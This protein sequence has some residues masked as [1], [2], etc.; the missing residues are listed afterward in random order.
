V[1]ALPGSIFSPTS[2][3]PNSLIKAGAKLVQTAQDIL[4]EL[5]VECTE[6]SRKEFSLGEKEK[7]IYDLLEEP[8]SVDTIKEKSSLETSFIIATLSF[9]E[10]KELVK[11]LGQDIWQKV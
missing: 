10:L 7:I 11:N 3:G 6:N 1:F 4:E 5:G 9:L 8:L 2:R